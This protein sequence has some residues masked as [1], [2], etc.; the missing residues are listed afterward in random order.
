[1][2]LSGI[3]AIL[4]LSVAVNGWVAIIPEIVLGLGAALTALN[5]D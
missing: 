2:K 4:T 3:F 1:M 5:M